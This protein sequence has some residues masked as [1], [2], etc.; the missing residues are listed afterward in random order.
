[1]RGDTTCR[2]PVRREVSRAYLAVDEI[3]ACMGV[4]GAMHLS[5]TDQVHRYVRIVRPHWTTDDDRP[6]GQILDLSR[7]LLRD[8]QDASSGMTCIL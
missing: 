2:F 5:L 1:M 7:C 4:D 6:L 3:A 8:Y